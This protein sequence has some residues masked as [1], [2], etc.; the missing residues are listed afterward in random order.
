MIND[1]QERKKKINNE[2]RENQKNPEI[3]AT[4]KGQNIQNLENTKKE[5]RNLEQELSSAEEK[6][7][8]INNN[9]KDVQEKLA[10]LREDKARNEATLEGIST[11]KKDLF[12][13]I[14]A[15]LNITDEI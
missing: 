3:I 4:T 5:V 12:Y 6:F 10:T 7:N 8:K 1:L 15:E 2:M 13:S 9:I 11:R 14:N